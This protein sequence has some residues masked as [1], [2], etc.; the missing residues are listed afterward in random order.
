M[1]NDIKKDLTKEEKMN[2]IAKNIAVR[3]ESNSY[4]NLGVGLPTLVASYIKPEQNINLHSENGLIGGTGDMKFDDLDANK[5]IVSS[6]GYPTRYRKGTAFFDS[7]I[8]FG[9]IRGGHISATVLGTMEVDKDGNIANYMI[10]GKFVAGMGGAMDLCASS[11]KVI[12]ATYHTNNGKPKILNECKLPLTA[13]NAVSLVVTEKAVIELK[14]GE[15]HLVAY[16]PFYDL[17]QIIG[18]IEPE[19][20]V[21]E[22]LEEMII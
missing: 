19:V 5:D 7:S 13:K 15:V 16:N 4:V 2:I 9:I 22:N 1:S 11:A 17:E 21:S 12:V 20:I 6:S 8:S 10:P 3:L 18:E 14:N